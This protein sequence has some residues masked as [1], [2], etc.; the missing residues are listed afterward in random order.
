MISS[1]TLKETSSFQKE[2]FKKTFGIF[3]SVST[4]ILFKFL[5]PQV[6]NPNAPNPSGL[7]SLQIA[8]RQNHSEIVATLLEMLAKKFKSN[9]EA[10]MNT[11][12]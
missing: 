6:E 8:S 11:L 3:Q 12:R 10:I 2:E 4:E 1:L 7:S 9:S 5:A